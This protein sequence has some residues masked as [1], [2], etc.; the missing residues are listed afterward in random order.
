MSPLI[1]EDGDFRMFQCTQTWGCTGD[2]GRH[3]VPQL[4]HV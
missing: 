4:K 2:E 3:R 1:W